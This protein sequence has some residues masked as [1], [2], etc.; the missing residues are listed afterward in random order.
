MAVGRWIRGGRRAE[1]R[2][3]SVRGG[4]VSVEAGE[5]VVLVSASGRWGSRYW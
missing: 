4:F 2:E 3:W 5:I 1:Q